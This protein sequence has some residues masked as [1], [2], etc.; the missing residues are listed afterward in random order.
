M[1]AHV[2]GETHGLEHL[3][4]EHAAVSYL[5]PFVE[6]RMPGVDLQRRLSAAIG[7]KELRMRRGRRRRTSV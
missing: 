3:R 1:H 4:A 6:Q 7:Y 5:H 2:F